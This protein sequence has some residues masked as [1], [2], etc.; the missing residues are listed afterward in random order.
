MTD[1]RPPGSGDGDG[2]DVVRE[3]DEAREAVAGAGRR[4]TSRRELAANPRFEDVSPEVGVLDPDAFDDLLD[5]DPDAALSLLAEMAGATDSGLRE[6][7]RRLA[8]RILVDVARVGSARRR[9]VG[10]I[11]PTRGGGTDGDIDLDASLDAI[12]AGRAAGHA[13]HAEDLILRTWQRPETALCLL[14]DRSGSMQGERLAAAA[15]AAAAV[16]YRNPVDCSVVAFSDEAIVLRSQGEHRAD[17]ELVG[18]ILRLRGHGT[19]DVG[20]ALRVAREQLSRSRAGRKVVLLLSD[21][22]S[23]AGG[24]PIPAAAALEE[25]AIVAP[26]DDMADADA[27]AESVGAR[28]VPLAGPADV[29]AALAAAL[30]G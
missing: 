30:L 4:T 28:C 11:I 13:I 27:L 8:G 22:R 26:A 6:L 1:H 16:S 25:V 14:I 29:P 7:A 24:D 17:D 20:L 15:V 5:E 12:V 3:G 10:R 18:D 23:T 9:G 2:S 21:C 19:T